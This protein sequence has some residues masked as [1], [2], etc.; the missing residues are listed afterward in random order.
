MAIASFQAPLLIP[1][2][3]A[4]FKGSPIPKCPETQRPRDPTK[5]PI[6]QFS[7]SIMPFHSHPMPYHLCSW[8][9]CWQWF[10]A[11]VL[12]VPQFYADNV[13]WLAWLR[14]KCP[15]KKKKQAD[16]FFSSVSA[17]SGSRLCVGVC[18]GLWEAPFFSLFFPFA[19]RS[20]LFGSRIYPMGSVPEIVR[21]EAGTGMRGARYYYYRRK[22]GGRELI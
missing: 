16:F 12:A 17:G 6:L 2:N 8:N 7:S 4:L 1:Q 5:Y 18:V 9:R 19:A 10:L 14:G 15:E 20:C 3:R 22:Y 11:V 21:E 13:R